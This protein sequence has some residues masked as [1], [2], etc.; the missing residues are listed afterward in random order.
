MAVGATAVFCAVLGLRHRLGLVEGAFLLALHAL[1]LAAA[2]WLGSE[3]SAG[4][5]CVCGD[6]SA[7]AIVRYSTALLYPRGRRRMKWIKPE[8]EI[9]DLCTEV[10]LYLYNR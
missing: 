9:I 4:P 8:F 6:T 7:A 5:D 3:R 1:Y 10:T 2:V